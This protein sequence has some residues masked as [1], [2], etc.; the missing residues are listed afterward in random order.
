LI[1]K[2]QFMRNLRHN[3]LFSFL[4]IAPFLSFAQTTKTLTLDEAIQLGLSNSKQIK[5]TGTKLDIAK[6]K[7]LQ[8]YNAQIPAVTLNSAYSHLSNNVDPFVLGAF[9]VPQII[10]QFTNRLSA[11]QIVFSGLRATNFYQSSQFLEKAAALDVD[12]DKIEVKNNIVAAYYNFY[13]LGASRDILIENINVLRGRLND[14]KNFVKQG[15]ALEN[16]Q[17]KAELAVSQLEMTQKEVNNAIEVAN[18]NLA[19]LLGLPTETKFELDKNTLFSEKTVGDLNSYLSGINS[20][21]DLSASDL[22]SQAANK[23]IEVAKGGMYPIVSVGANAYYNNPNQRMFPP[24]A[25]FKG[26]WDIGIGL[27]YNLTNLYTGKYQIQEAQANVAQ[28]NLLKDQLSDAAKMEVNSNYFAYQ[29]AIEKIKLMEKAITQTIENQRVM[30]NRYNSQL[31]T[32]GE[33]LDSDFLVLQ[34]KINSE[35]AKADAELAYYKLLK[36]VGK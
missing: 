14:A 30:K 5:V 3:L 10:N 18:F 17:L 21:P 4:L 24:A 15:T 7:K 1:K 11:N 12:K 20:R 26:T 29:T 31:S 28:A 32:I 35:T 34:A 25:T 6:A 13:K 16:D 23:M 36:A 9:E 33:L 19:L 22:R 8:Y 27:S 2:N